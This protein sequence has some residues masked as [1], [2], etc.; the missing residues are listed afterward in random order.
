MPTKSRALP[1]DDQE[2]KSFEFQGETYYVKNKFK[3]ARFMRTLNDSP[4]DAI[5]LVLPDA[6]FNRFLDLEMSMDDLKDF[7]EGLSTALAGAPSKN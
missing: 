5:E 7:L 3:V 6:D 4:I 2:M 1:V